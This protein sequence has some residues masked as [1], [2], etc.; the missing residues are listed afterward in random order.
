V[1]PRG[2]L[3][4]L[5]AVKRISRR[6]MEQTLRVQEGLASLSSAVQ[7]NISGMHVVKAYDAVSGGG[8]GPS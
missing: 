7:E 6:L 5:F 3:K 2:G 1:V 8:R 4:W